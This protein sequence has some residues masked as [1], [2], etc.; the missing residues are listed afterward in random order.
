M[1]P[2]RETIRSHLG[3]DIGESTL[4]LYTLLG[5]PRSS[6]AN[7]IKTAFSVAA[8]RW[9]E[10]D[11]QSNPAMANQVGALLKEAK[12]VLL[13]DQ[14]R[15][16]YDLTLEP[17][18]NLDSEETMESNGFPAGDPNSPFDE[19]VFRALLHSKKLDATPEQFTTQELENRYSQL[20]SLVTA[21]RNAD[22][23]QI[24]DLPTY[25][26]DG[27][28][29]QSDYRFDS[30]TPVLGGDREV[31]FE[32]PMQSFGNDS[33]HT[34]PLTRI[35]PHVVSRKKSD[36][37]QKAVTLGLF[38]FGGALIAGVG[39]YALYRGSGP[40]KSELV[41]SAPAG[42]ANVSTDTSGSSSS[43]VASPEP[44]PPEPTL[45][46]QAGT[47]EMPDIAAT[48]SGTSPVM[49]MPIESEPAE[50]MSPALVSEP[51]D[52]PNTDSGMEVPQVVASEEIEL[53]LGEMD[54]ALQRGDF[55]SFRQLAS[56]MPPTKSDSVTVDSVSADDGLQAKQARLLQIGELYQAAHEA[57]EQAK[58]KLKAGS[59]LIVGS[60]ELKVAGADVDSLSVK[61]LG[62]VKS[63]PWRELPLGITLAILDESLP[64]NTPEDAA[65]KAAFLKYHSNSD[66][67]KQ[68]QIAK[69]VE[70]SKGSGKVRSDFALAFL[71]KYK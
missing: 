69:L 71:D 16:A 49:N 13:D 8:K 28:D 64:A 66:D 52:A 15:A 50:G 30:T 31:S 33:I 12:R 39:L 21:E 11:R 54:A 4:T 67:V 25:E 20:M 47:S 58:S 17:E 22:S 61:S 40:S 56:A 38:A 6:T 14:L 60:R 46:A 48:S 68:A 10:S 32:P 42:P 19:S 1:E 43:L 23:H 65:A 29:Y 2:L 41:S 5:L 62:G 59:S 45:P 26:L 70:Q 53:K 55:E 9:N 63:Y 18:L 34:D 7:E 35:S 57:F 24:I 37:R 3:L 44:T 51:V 36:P 27:Y